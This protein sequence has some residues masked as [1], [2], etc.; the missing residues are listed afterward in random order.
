MDRGKMF[1]FLE[2][3]PD[4]ARCYR[5]AM[6]HLEKYRHLLAEEDGMVEHTRGDIAEDLINCAARMCCFMTPSDVGTILERAMAISVFHYYDH[7]GNWEREKRPRERKVHLFTFED[8]RDF[9]RREVETAGP[10]FD[11]HLDLA[12]DCWLRARDRGLRLPGV[13]TVLPSDLYRYDPETGR[14]SGWGIGPETDY[15]AALW[16]R[17]DNARQASNY[18]EGLRLTLALAIYKRWKRLEGEPV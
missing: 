17:I 1:A 9:L 7:L 2:E 12:A 6:E 8:V 4:K 13:E 11:Y 15:E 14:L 10:L 3:L 18:D 16:A 5:I